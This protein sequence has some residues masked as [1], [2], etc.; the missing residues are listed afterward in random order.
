MAKKV[1]LVDRDDNVVGYKEK[2]EAHHNPAPLHRA[3]SVVIFDKAH[4]KM[5]LQK[6]SK[7]KPTWPRFWSNACCTHPFIGELY[8]SAA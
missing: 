7:E 4:K 6:R 5:L 8:K 2:Y 3:I 1:V